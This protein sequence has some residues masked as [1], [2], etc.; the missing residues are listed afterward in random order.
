MAGESWM[1]YEDPS[2]EYHR[3]VR[4]EP[5]TTSELV[6]FLGKTSSL[7]VAGLYGCTSVIA[8]SRRGAWA[9]HSWEAPS[10]TPWSEDP[11]PPTDLEQLE[12]F[13]RD[14]LEALHKGTSR[15][16]VYGLSEMRVTTNSDLFPTSHLMEDDADPHVFIFTPY[17]RGTLGTSNWNN[18][19]PTGLTEEWGQ[20]D[21]LPSKNQQIENEVKA[22]FRI[23]NG[24]VVPYE[25][26]LYAPREGYVG[27]DLGDKY[28]DSNRGKVLVQY[29][30]AKSCQE[31]ASWRVWFEG[32]ELAASHQ[33]SWT[34]SVNQI[35][36][37]NQQGTL[38][39]R[40]DS[41][42][43]VVACPL[44]SSTVIPSVSSTNQGTSLL[45]NKH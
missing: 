20:D 15:F 26:V 16:H 11:S 37:S 24:L 40:Q 29:Q 2:Q 17:E 34:P 10:F 30:P 9:S 44:P 35:A 12:I 25:K 38:K 43:S 39:H 1:A 45:S 7:A 28:F 4:L 31:K 19:F 42:D 21:G 14:V 32:H 27:E 36:A 41:T 18:E 22:I 3:G 23:P 33:S 13:R 5:G 8:I 6:P